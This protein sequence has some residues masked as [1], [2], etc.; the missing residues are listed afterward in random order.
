MELDGNALATLFFGVEVLQNI[1]F[2]FQ[3]HGVNVKVN[4][5]TKWSSAGL[6]SPQIQFNF[7]TVLQ[8]LTDILMK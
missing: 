1:T 7:V 8:L 4:S 6:C 2:D 3:G 5:A